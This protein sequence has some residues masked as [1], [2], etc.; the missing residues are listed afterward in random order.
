L[1]AL[2]AQIEPHFLF[3][4]LANVA[5]LIDSAPDKARLMLTRL[6]EL[7]RASLAASRATRVDIGG[8]LDLVRAHLDILAIRMGARLHYTID[9]PDGVRAW[10]VP[11]L[12]IQP[13]VENA[14]KRGLEPKMEGG[15]VTIRVRAE[16][17]VLQVEV[18]DDGLGFAPSGSSGVGL[19]NLRDRLAA[20]YDGRAALKIES[21]SPGTRVRASLHLDIP[22]PPEHPMTTALIADDEPHLAEFLRSRLAQVWPELEL[23][24]VVE[25]GI[26]ALRMARERKPDIVF[27]D[28]RMPGLTGLEVARQVRADAQRPR[29]VFVTAY[30]QYA[31]DALDADAVGYLLKPVNDDRLERTV[32]KLRTAVTQRQ[33]LPDLTRLLEQLAQH[34]GAPGAQA[35][36]WI[37]ASR[38]AADGEVTEQIAV[39]DVLY[40]LADGRC[41]RCWAEP[42]GRR[43]RRAGG[44]LQSRRCASFSPGHPTSPPRRCVF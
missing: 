40:F 18:E 28:I 17:E 11:P 29:V 13:L 15:T 25:N 44:S 26:D 38:R 34:V 37:R 42:R 32:A 41:R 5:S 7:L 43:S 4:A 10:P 24:T 30:D 35:L 36:R 39:G 3:N 22:G 33:D 1:R 27:L 6:I 20:L 16:A 21:L 31:I 8:E 19:T 23:V 12:L 2:Q 9:A 14:I